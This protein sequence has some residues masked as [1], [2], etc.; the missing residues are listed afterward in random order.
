MIVR[1]DHVGVVAHSIEE[2]SAVLVET[3]GFPIDTDRT[4]LPEGNLFK[5]QNTRI[6]FVK[7]GVGKTRIE[8]LI[9]QDTVS[10]I[11]KYLAKRGPGLHHMGYAV[12]SVAD[13]ARSLRE[14]GLPQIDL[15]PDAGAAFFYPKSTMGIL[16]ELVPDRTRE[17]V[18]TTER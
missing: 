4:R 3:L 2:A 16:T 8:I 18:H 11:A 1:L 12:D 7:V 13:E 6:F 9:P 10:G 5:P 15:G 14:K 17:R